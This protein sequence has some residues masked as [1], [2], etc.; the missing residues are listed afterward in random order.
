MPSAAASSTRSSTLSFPV[1]ARLRRTG[2]FTTIVMM[3]ELMD[4]GFAPI[5]TFLSFV[6]VRP[7]SRLPHTGAPRGLCTTLKDEVNADL[8][9]FIER[10]E[11][12]RAA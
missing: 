5:A 11:A 6:A 2:A 3:I 10:K 12:Q 9:A 8:L 7:T 4:R 1:L